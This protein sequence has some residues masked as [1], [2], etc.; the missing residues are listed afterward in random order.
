MANA[1]DDVVKNGVASQVRA[2]DGTL[3]GAGRDRRAARRGIRGLTIGA[4]ALISL[5][6]FEA[7]AVAT[8]MPAVAS[9]LNGLTVYALAFG[10]PLATS[11]VGMAVAG[12]WADGSG[13]RRPLVVG[14]ALFAAGLLLCGTAPQIVQFVAGRGVQG[15]GAGMET[16]AIYA[17]VG[18]V[19]PETQR[20]RLFAWF[21]AA[22]VLP[23]MIGPAVSGLILHAL[24]WR[25]V[26]LLVPALAIPATLVMW[27]AVRDVARPDRAAS[28]A[29][30]VA[31]PGRIRARVLFAVGAGL[32]AAVLQVA[33]TKPQLPWRVVA[34]LALAAVVW[35]AHGLLPDGV[36]RLGRGVPSVVAVRGLIAA[37]FA[38]AETYLPLLLVR[39]H[40]WDPT[41]AGLVLTL[42]AVAWSTG[43][44]IQGRYPAPEARYGMARIGTVLLAVGVGTFLLTAL[45]G[46]PGWIA[47]IGW[48]L[49]GGGMGLVYSSTSL[50]ALHLS[51]PERHGEA[52]SALT[53]GEALTQSVALALGGA[54][55]A[56]LL[57]A[58]I[59][60]DAPAGP[61]PY[62]AAIG[63]AVAAAAL[64]AVAA[65]RMRP[66]TA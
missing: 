61:T 19:V 50:L 5:T 65:W 37:S 35:C 22:W 38:G 33:G 40:R 26:F 44:W 64:S 10:A 57:P 52:S 47:P 9:A 7:L 25:A 56:L 66:A 11:V 3:D 29:G 16:V 36:F 53:T 41:L 17:L 43:A 45:P 4:V 21:S 63:V 31:D 39:E 12:A 34:V 24:G 55:F 27:P 28:P 18:S 48:V 59:A 58:R 51:P 46:V 1:M 49:G 20:P 42:G 15:L 2:D 23:A 13:A 14:V 60:A 30:Q 32:T 62:L 54:L 6:A 8:V